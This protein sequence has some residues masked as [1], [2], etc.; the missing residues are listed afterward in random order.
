MKESPFQGF[1]PK[2]NFS[3]AQVH[4]R[5]ANTLRRFGQFA[6]N[7]KALHDASRK[8]VS[9]INSHQDLVITAD[10]PVYALGKQVQW[11][12]SDRFKNFVWMMG[13]LHIEMT[14]LNALGD[15]MEGS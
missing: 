2:I 13:P 15:W 11:M 5:I 7:G 14:L 6:W 3:T 8:I 9:T 4:Q 10:Q 12:Y 1:I